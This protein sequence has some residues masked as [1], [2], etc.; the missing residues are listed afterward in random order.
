MLV[1]TDDFEHG[2]LHYGETLMT[3][4]GGC[5]LLTQPSQRGNWVLTGHRVSGGNEGMLSSKWPVAGRSGC[6]R[7]FLGS[8]QTSSLLWL[9]YLKMKYFTHTLDKF[10]CLF[11]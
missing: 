11:H 9:L 3:W 6:I 2:R 1:A 5:M 7:T 4:G 10:L 8:S